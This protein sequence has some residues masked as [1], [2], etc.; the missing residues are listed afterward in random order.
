[1]ARPLSGGPE[2]V[3][4]YNPNDFAIAL[5]GWSLNHTGSTINSD[6]LFKSGV[7][8]GKTTLLLT[9]DATSQATGNAS[10]VIDLG[11]QGFLGVGMFNGLEDGTGELKLRYTQLDEARPYDVSKAEWGGD[12]QL[13][14]IV[15]QSLAWDGNSSA[16]TSWFIEDTPTPGDP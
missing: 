4:I 16:T 14:M 15:G 9:G 1:M 6:Y 5:R 13:F 7:I 11:L 8:A 3:E 10:Q 12:T 2:W